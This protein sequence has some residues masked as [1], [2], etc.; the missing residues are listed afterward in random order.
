MM[1]RLRVAMHCAL[2]GNE[3][4]STR[5]A[6]HAANQSSLADRFTRAQAALASAEEH[7]R[8][9][10]RNVSNGWYI[11]DRL[12][13]GFWSPEIFNVFNLRISTVAPPPSIAF[14]C[15]RRNE[16]ERLL[17]SVDRSFEER[18]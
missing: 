14:A 10:T 7:L 6:S 9:A 11:R 4:T 1:S 17:G 12:G 3:M 18:V 16:R 5:S 2:G 15:L 8:A 13:N